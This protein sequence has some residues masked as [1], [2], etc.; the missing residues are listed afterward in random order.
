MPVISKHV[1]NITQTIKY[2]IIALL[3][4]KLHFQSHYAVSICP[5]MQILS[6]GIMST[7]ILSAYLCEFAVTCYLSSW[8]LVAD[9]REHLH[10]FLLAAATRVSAHVL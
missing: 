8:C 6:T 9:S 7:G 10:P 1:Y 5:T 2:A 4:I 3:L